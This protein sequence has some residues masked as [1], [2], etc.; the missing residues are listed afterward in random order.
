MI[1]VDSNV[2]MYFVG[3]EHPHRDEARTFFARARRLDL[4]LVTSAEV[5]QE[6]LHR[7]LR[8]PRRHLLQAAFDLVDATVDDLWGIDRRDILLA[9]ALAAR[10]PDLQARDLV[11]LACCLRRKPKRV[12]TFDRSLES[13]WRTH[14]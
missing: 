11:H 7:Y 4:G 14:S 5:L 3:A 10:H 1:F 13:A 2:F 12:M 6:L 9:R 8:D